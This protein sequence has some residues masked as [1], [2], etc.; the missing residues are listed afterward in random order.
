MLT[1]WRLKAM[2]ELL[3]RQRDTGMPRLAIG[4][5]IQLIMAAC[6]L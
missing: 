2:G 1:T 6:D 5:R 4:R 3:C